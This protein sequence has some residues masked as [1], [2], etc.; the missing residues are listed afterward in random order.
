MNTTTADIETCPHCGGI[1]NGRCHRIKAI[2]YHENGTV[3]R[4]EYHSEP[5]SFDWQDIEP[6][7]MNPDIRWHVPPDM[8]SPSVSFA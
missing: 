8:R 6:V 4:I 7:V 5:R 2:E 3:K 1:H